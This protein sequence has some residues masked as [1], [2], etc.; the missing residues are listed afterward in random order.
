MN[1][2]QQVKLPKIRSRLTLVQEAHSTVFLDIPKMRK[3]MADN[4]NSIYVWSHVKTEML[5]D[6]IQRA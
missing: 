4:N 3:N 2:H 5:L 1:I 6:L